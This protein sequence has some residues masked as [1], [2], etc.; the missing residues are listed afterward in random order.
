ME[1]RIE[2]PD[3]K[4][5]LVE[6]EGVAV[7][8]ASAELLG[9]VDQVCGRLAG[10]LTLESLAA[11]ESIRAVRAMF[12]AWRV[13]PA[14]YRQSGEALLRRVVQGKGL[15]RVSNVVDINNLGSCETGWSYG[16]YDRARVRPP[17][18]FR[19]GRPAESYE[20]IGKKL[21]ELDGRPVLADAEGP[22]GSPI[23]DSTRSMVTEKTAD[24]LTVV[25]CPAAAPARELDAAL[26]RHSARL[27][28]YAGARATRTRVILPE[29]P[30]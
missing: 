29:T 28:R 5:G 19:S 7:S 16:S 11:L 20:A 10:E 14:R 8:A 9:E 18:T 1:W 15:Y 13:D 24:V 30:I 25:F 26:E 23:S 21:W 4:L 3:V 17:F 2:L 6:A 12:H 22:F 27:G